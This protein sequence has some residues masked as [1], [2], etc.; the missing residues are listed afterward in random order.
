MT[1]G[2]RPIPTPRP[3]D[4][5]S[6]CARCRCPLTAYSAIGDLRCDS[7]G[8]PVAIWCESCG[9]LPRRERGWE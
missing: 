1:S 5:A 8:K 7:A 2:V 4:P 6:Q 3:Y 9:R